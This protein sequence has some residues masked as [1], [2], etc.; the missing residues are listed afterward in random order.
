MKQKK[1]IYLSAL[2]LFIVSVKGFCAIDDFR[3]D[4]NTLAIGE[5]FAG[6]PQAQK[7]LNPAAVFQTQRGQLFYTHTSM[8]PLDLGSQLLVI[9]MGSISFALLDERIQDVGGFEY[10]ERMYQLSYGIKIGK[11]AG[12]GFNVR[13]YSSECGDFTNKAYAYDLAVVGSWTHFS[14]GALIRD[15]GCNIISP[16]SEDEAILPSSR[17]GVSVTLPYGGKIN[18]DYDEKQQ[19]YFGYQQEISHGL[20]F[21]AGIQG[22]EPRLGFGIRDQRISFDYAYSINQFCNE[23]RIAFGINF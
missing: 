18:L 14:L 12:L 8:Q 13:E 15:L 20:L 17:V 16:V 7:Y 19:T 3:I 4:A 23:Q 22:G 21:R 2:L 11:G 10:K 9:N 6:D 1:I 5:T